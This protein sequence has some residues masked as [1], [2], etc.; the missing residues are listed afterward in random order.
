[1][2]RNRS[3][4]KL[5]G[6]L[7]GLTFYQQ[8]G[9]SFVKTKG[10]VSKKRIA[11]DPAFRRTRE[12]MQEF[13]G[14]AK[15]GKAMRTAFSG[16]VKLMADTYFTARLTG[17]MKRINRNG[18]GPRGQRI[19][20]VVANGE[21]LE[22]VEFNL[23]APMSQQFFAPYAPPAWNANRDIASWTV[24]DFDTDSFVRAPEGATHFRLVLAAG[25][26]SS[27][28]WVNALKS[29]EPIDE[30]ENGLGGVAFSGDIPLTGMV[31][32]DTILSVD[33]GLGAA[34]P[35]A[36]AA[37]AA[38]GIVFYQETNGSLYELAQGNAMRVAV[39]A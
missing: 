18:L 29:Y 25:L 16:I 13:G 14:A 5:E 21:L 37:I 23:D 12:N 4:V 27:Y 1:M 19:I 24:P 31:G 28:D 15:A 10:G 35:P 33:L 6:T 17:L 34:V 38:V 11:T 32:S 30:D 39:I 9:Q 7:D 20:D 22:G 2:A 26:V 36:T 8:D 3:F